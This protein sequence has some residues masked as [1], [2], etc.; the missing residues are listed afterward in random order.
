MNATTYQNDS[1]VKFI[2]NVVPTNWKTG[3]LVKIVPKYKSISKR[4]CKNILKKSFEEH[5]INLLING[6]LYRMM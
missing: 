5:L 6:H 2:V 4:P 3:T 1:T